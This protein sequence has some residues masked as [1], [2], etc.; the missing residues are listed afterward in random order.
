MGQL[1]LP[2]SLGRIASP[3]TRIERRAEST[4]V[5]HY[6]IGPVGVSLD[7]TV[8]SVHKNYHE[9][10]C[11]Y[12]TPH[13]CGPS[14]PVRVF[15]RRSWR[16]G[17]LHFHIEGDIAEAFTVRKEHQVLPHVE[18]VVNLSIARY[19]P[20]YIQIH[21]AVLSKDGRGLILAGA[22]GAG[23]TT[24]A[25]ALLMRGW[26]Y[27]TDE[28]A[29]I[30]P[31]TLRLVPYPKALSIKDGSVAVLAALG[32]P[33]NDEVFERRDKG[34]IRCVS[35]LR[36]RPDA[37]SGP[38]GVAMVVFPEHVP[39]A[40]PQLTRISNAEAGFELSRRCFN[41][42]KYRRFSLETILAASRRASCFRLVSADLAQ[43]CDLIESAWTEMKMIE[44]GS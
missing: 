43:T 21:A 12:E 2:L 19:L 34:P 7:C 39:Q 29:L 26:Q 30:D 44:G 11:P 24:L 13:P 40:A 41:F 10:Y 25:A 14:F 18:A 5:R 1:T 35:P 17:R 15:A 22:P 38:C 28:F 6:R 20:H 32:F 4:K 23:K 9:R 42:L 16:T 3:S 36:C 31:D 33:V 37:V 27:A 8:P